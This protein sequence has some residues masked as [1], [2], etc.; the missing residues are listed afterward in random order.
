MRIPNYNKLVGSSEFSSVN[1]YDFDEIH[2]L[3]ALG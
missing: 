3:C 2:I 1:S